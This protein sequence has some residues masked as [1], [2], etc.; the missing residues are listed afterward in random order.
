MSKD[1]CNTVITIP[2]FSGTCWFNALLMCMFYSQ[3]MRDLLL[4]NLKNSDLYVRNKEFYEIIMDIMQNRYRKVK[5]ED[6]IFFNQLKPEKML[7]LLHSIDP[8]H[9][10][11]NPSITAG[12]QGIYYFVRLF[13]Y[14]G[15]KKE[16]IFL[17]KDKNKFIY[18]VLNNKPY[19]KEM[20][21]KKHNKD[22]VRY[23]WQY[24]SPPKINFK[25]VLSRN[26]KVLVVTSIYNHIRNNKNIMFETS[27]GKYI[28]DTL[29]F[30]GKTYKLDSMLLTN[31]NADTCKKTHQIAGI[32]CEENR[33]LYNGWIRYSTD[34]SMTYFTQENPCELIKYD[35]SRKN[36][37]FCLS[38]D[39][40]G[41][42]K[43][44]QKELCFNN[45]NEKYTSLIYVIDKSTSKPVD[46][47]NKSVDKPN[48]P[49]KECP[50]DKILNP[51]TNRCVSK[52]GAI[53]LSIIN[54][55]NNN[56]PKHV[57]KPKPVKECPKDKILNPKTNRCVSKTGTIGKQLL[58]I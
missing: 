20:K 4:K 9:F 52:T 34:P 11:F 3:G 1:I 50:E 31:Y 47:P 16:V 41:I 21:S 28:D 30:N 43:G 55:Q 27:S 12:H 48:K 14:F 23:V 22:H 37:N 42:K 13:D 57:D 5:D 25:E 38:T 10:Y 44:N 51:K 53:G 54:Q 56:K 32:T 6:Q 58:K 8:K 33:Y 40:C 46:K 7:S 36:F 45:L 29:E 24:Y 18:S 39:K 26:T 35:W 49:V 19:V 15:L 17:N 2:Q